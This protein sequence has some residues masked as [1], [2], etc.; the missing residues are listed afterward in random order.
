ML[1]TLLSVLP[2]VSHV[3]FNI[4]MTGGCCYHTCF[5][6]KEMKSLNLRNLLWATAVCQPK[7]GCWR[8]VLSRSPPHLSELHKELGPHR[9]HLSKI[10]TPSSSQKVAPFC[11]NDLDMCSWLA[12]VP[13]FS[14]CG[15]YPF[16][17]RTHGCLSARRC[18]PCS[19]I[20][21][22]IGLF[23]SEAESKNPQPPAYPRNYSTSTFT[24]SSD[25]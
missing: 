10:C 25:R 18:Q 20:W 3:A 12:K 5:T 23:S 13:S 11:H 22:L 8:P 19:W 16:V 24:P 9:G 4:V 14:A 15:N 21:I 17:S 2:M 6:G 7:S 1:D